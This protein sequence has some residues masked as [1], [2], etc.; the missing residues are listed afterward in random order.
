MSLSDGAPRAV[1]GSRSGDVA[2]LATGPR[3]DA[4]THL[5]LD[6]PIVATLLRLATPN[7]LVMVVQA[8]V[9]LIETY[10]IAKLGT[11]ALAGVALRA[12]VA[13]VNAFG[14]LDIVFANADIGA[15]RPVGQTSLTAFEEVT[16]TNLTAVCFT[17][18]FLASDDA[19]N[20]TGASKGIG[21]AL[22][23][24]LAAASAAG[25]VNYAADKAGAE[26]TVSE[27]TRGVAGRWRSRRTSPT[28]PTCSACSRK[29]SRPSA[30]STC[31]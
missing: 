4:R 15:A 18:L 19:S 28:R 31:W 8:S 10:C 12:V 21:A 17:V 25:A 22:A 26:R 5:L 7:V 13:A 20:V 24:G 6:G 16:R 23:K 2:R 1:I 30:P 11:D 9:G 3:F 29:R 27:I 14:K